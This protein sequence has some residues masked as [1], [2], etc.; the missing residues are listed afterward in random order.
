RGGLRWSDRTED[1]RTE[2]LGLQK[3]QTPKNVV[4]VPNGSKGGFILKHDSM[5]DADFNIR[6][7]AINCYKDFLRSMLDI[8]DNVISGVIVPL[9]G[10]VCHDAE[11]KYLVVAADKGTA[12][13]SNYANEIAAEYKFWLDDAF[14]SGG[15]SGYDHK[16]LAITSRGAWV[17]TE[18]HFA[19]LGIDIINNSFTAIAIGDMAGDVCGNGLLMSRNMKVIAAFNHVNIFIDPDPDLEIS[20]NERKRLFDLPRSTWEDYNVDYISK[21]GGIFSRSTKSIDIT[22]EMARLFNIDAKKLNPSELIK[23]ILCTEVDLIW[24]GGIGTFVKSTNET[25]D[26][27]G[28]KANDSLRVD[29][30]SIKARIFAEGGNLGITQLGR[31]EMSS[32][33]RCLNADFI[34]NSAGV[35]CSDMEVNL[36]IL[37]SI[38]IDRGLL[39]TNSRDI[40][41]EAVQNEVCS[42]ILEKI[43]KRQNRSITFA[44]LIS[45]VCVIEQYQNLINQLEK[46]GLLNRKM[47]YL[48]DDNEIIQMLK[49]NRGFKRPQIAL[50]IAYTKMYLNDR[51]LDGELVQNK[52]FEK[53]LFNYFPLKVRNE[54]GHIINDHPLKNEIIANYI[55]NYIINY[56]GPLLVARVVES[57]GLHEMEV[58]KIWF[59][60]KDIYKLDQ[61]FDKIEWL[62]LQIDM[63]LS[64]EMM[65][66]IALFMRKLCEWFYRNYSSSINIDLTIQEFFDDVALLYE[67]ID[68]IADNETLKIYNQNIKLLE[69]KGITIDIAKKIESLEIASSFLPIIRIY[70]RLRFYDRKQISLLSVA[71]V[72]FLL[73]DNLSLPWLREMSRSLESYSYWQN[74][75]LNTLFDSLSDLQTNLTIIVIRSLDSYIELKEEDMVQEWVKNNKRSVDHY[76]YFLSE[77]QIR[78]RIDIDKLVVIIKY[79][80]RIGG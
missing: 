41:L 60:I 59:T 78:G 9:Q 23:A 17:S 79:L 14:A 13:F 39:T 20:Y 10:I 34:D 18:H 25:H 52:Y 27:V 57:T 73:G 8:T 65:E 51:I 32:N 40:L 12:T 80:E 37:C 43:N 24:N 28:D 4:I 36:K 69:E 1:F 38:A 47:E 21:G 64:G 48:P 7:F 55:S 54:L 53:Y 19:R 76:R 50:I 31:I 77:L 42:M 6:E 46:S 68:A 58:V 70:N 72:Y 16:V 22:P 2:V 49:D 44:E 56:S 45:S 26:M 15:S 74:L 29:G 63:K 5:H 62:E 66:K 30:K 75:S 35:S 67:N 61:L 11:D 3:A 71:K 33:N